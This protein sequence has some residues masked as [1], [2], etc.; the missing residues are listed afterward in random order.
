MNATY[1]FNACGAHKPS[2]TFGLDLCRL[3][4]WPRAFFLREVSALF[5]YSSGRTYALTMTTTGFSST[6]SEVLLG[7]LELATRSVLPLF[8]FLAGNINGNSTISIPLRILHFISLSSSLVFRSKQVRSA[9]QAV[10]ELPETKTAGISRS[11]EHKAICRP[12]SSR[13]GSELR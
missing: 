13:D 7:P 4:R 3:C 1:L 5:T 9:Q 8:D 2:R 11:G 12:P 6:F 10:P